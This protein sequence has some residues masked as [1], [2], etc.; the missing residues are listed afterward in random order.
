[1]DNRRYYMIRNIILALGTV[2]F[3]ALAIYTVYLH[4]HCSII[5]YIANKG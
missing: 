2:S 5:S 4:D 3:I 1:M